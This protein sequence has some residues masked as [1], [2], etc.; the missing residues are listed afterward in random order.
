VEK[1]AGIALGLAL[2]GAAGLS[3]AMAQDEGVTVG[4]EATLTAAPTAGDI[5]ALVN[6]IF[7]QVFGET[8][9]ADDGVAADDSTTTGSDLSVGGS[10]GGTITMGGGMGGDISI[11]GGSGS[12]GSS[13]GTVYG[14]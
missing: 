12:S 7:A 13:G 10:M 5:E 9:V 2:F 1:V 14:G 11:G 4:G 6:S 3:G 8:G